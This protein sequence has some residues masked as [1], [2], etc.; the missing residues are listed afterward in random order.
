MALSSFTTGASS[1]GS[2]TGGI[3]V[4]RA[5]DILLRRYLDHLFHDEHLL[6]RQV[7]IEHG[8]DI[9]GRSGDKL[10]AVAGPAFDLL[11]KVD[12]R[13]LRDG[14][15]ERA[16]H[17]EQGENHIVLQKFLGEESDGLRVGQPGAYVGEGNAMRISDS[18]GDLFI[19]TGVLVEKEFGERVSRKSLFRCS[20]QRGFQLDRLDNSR[21]RSRGREVWVRGWSSIGAFQ[22]WQTH[23]GA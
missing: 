7:G 8:T 6:A 3:R 13:G 20:E 19:R 17:Q 23:S 22:S 16:L 5:E 10:N 21:S 11:D 4:G 14:D 2:P 1:D 18:L 9:A 15:G 12:I